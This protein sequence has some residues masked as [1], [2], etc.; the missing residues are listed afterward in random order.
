M[1]LYQLP[2]VHVGLAS[3]TGNVDDNA[4]MSTI[5]FQTDFVAVYVKGGEAINVFSLGWISGRCHDG[6]FLL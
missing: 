6:E 2:V 4:Y 3:L 1:H 5:F